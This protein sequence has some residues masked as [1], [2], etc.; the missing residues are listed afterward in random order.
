MAVFIRDVPYSINEIV[1]AQELRPVLHGLPF[2]DTHD[3]SRH[4]TPMNFHVRLIPDKRARHS[5]TGKGVIT[6]P[7]Q[8]LA[9]L[10]VRYFTHVNKFRTRNKVIRFEASREPPQRNL[11]ADLQLMP[12]RDPQEILQ[13]RDRLI[14]VRN[15]E[16]VEARNVQFMY[17]CRDWVLSPEWEWCP[18][19]ENLLYPLQ[20]RLEETTR[21]LVIERFESQ[22]DSVMIRIKYLS[23][24]CIDLDTKTCS[25]VIYLSYAPSYE[26]ALYPPSGSKVPRNKLIALDPKHTEVAPFTWCCIRVVCSSPRSINLFR[27][28]AEKVKIPVTERDHEV[29]PRARYSQARRQRMQNWLATINWEVAFQ[30]EMMYR[31]IL[32]DPKE[33]W[34]LKRPTEDTIA[35]RLGV[36]GTI[37]VLR[38]FRLK[39][40]SSNN[41]AVNEET[42]VFDFFRDSVNEAAGLGTDFAFETGTSHFMCYHVYFTPSRMGLEGPFLDVSNRILRAYPEHQNHFIRVSFGDEENMK[43]RFDRREVDGSGFVHDRVGSIL[44]NGFVLCGRP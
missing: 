6:F 35:S 30:Y 8:A 22:N 31:D 19:P 2:S 28:M 39:L 33:I 34:S 15:E 7:S 9:D 17:E 20:L 37:N 25:F 29:L 23:V 21:E 4:A 44:K 43:F 18:N 16:G 41:W 26:Q 38:R 13:L 12:Y 5:H 32:L 27:S 42:N 36:R 1:L 40:N 3:S 11:L 14:D 24:D 10:A